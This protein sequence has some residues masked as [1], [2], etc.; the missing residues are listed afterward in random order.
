MLMPP[1]IQD[2]AFS[3]LW[4]KTG[5]DEKFITLRAREAQLARHV[6]DILAIARTLDMPLPPA[7][8]GLTTDAQAARQLRVAHPDAL[9]I[10]RE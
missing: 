7:K 5:C 4:R 8:D 9:N 2:Y 1:S 10:V 3:L 6:E